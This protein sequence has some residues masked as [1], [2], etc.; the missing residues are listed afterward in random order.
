MPR[1]AKHA[2]RLLNCLHIECTTAGNPNA[3]LAAI[4]WCEHVPQL[5]MY[6]T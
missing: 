1:T 5:R 3:V 6:L 2:T 4:M